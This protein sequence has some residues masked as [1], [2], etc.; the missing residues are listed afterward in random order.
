MHILN[1]YIRG[2]RALLIVRSVYGIVQEPANF[3]A[4]YYGKRTSD[5]QIVREYV[6]KVI[7]SINHET[8]IR[9]SWLLF[10]G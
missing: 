1:K 10:E 5:I 6:C 7:A 4:R 9:G 2:S 8:I 3:L